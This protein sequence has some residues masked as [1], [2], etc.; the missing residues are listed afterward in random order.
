MDFAFFA[1]GWLV[2]ALAF[3][4]P[5]CN[6]SVA[7]FS[8]R[9]VQHMVLTL[10]AAPLIVRGVLGSTPGKQ[11]MAQSFAVAA[12]TAFTACFWFWHS[13]LAYDETLKNNLVYWLMHATMFGAALALWVAVFR[14]HGFV[15]FFVVSA[16]GLQMSLL[17]AAADVRQRTALCGT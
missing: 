17:A 2:L 16:V 11:A 8:A 1:T 14:S 6:V 13:P 15:A 4:S 3:V 9:V 10:V 5:L 12:A 7:L